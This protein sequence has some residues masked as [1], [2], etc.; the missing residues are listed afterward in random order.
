MIFRKNIED[1]PIRESGM[2]KSISQI[3]QL[4]DEAKGKDKIELLRQN[5]SFPLRTILQTCFDPN[6]KWLLPE[7]APTYKPAIYTD[8]EGRLYNEAKHL[9]L[10]L[11]GGN[12]NLTNL[13]RGN[14]FIQM[15]ESVT[16]DDAKL[17][18]SIKDKKLPYE[19]ITV[20]IVNEAFPDLL[21]VK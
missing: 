2:K 20:K 9:Y 16:P 19:S 13:K 6:I 17:L 15:L 7:G 21:P 4:V 18:I 11:E 8:I 1:I 3:L 14:I 5:D 12:P 10:F